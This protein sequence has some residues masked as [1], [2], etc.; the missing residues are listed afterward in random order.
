[1]M[2]TIEIFNNLSKFYIGTWAY[3]GTLLDDNRWMQI[4]PSDHEERGRLEIY[5]QQVIKQVDIEALKVQVQSDYERV[6]HLELKPAPQNPEWRNE[7]D[8]L[9]DYAQDLGLKYA[10]MA[11]Q[12]P[13]STQFMY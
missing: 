5:Y 1:M 2:E 8:N 6:E 11:S 3:L 9:R 4:A 10:Q 12:S 13:Q 7:V